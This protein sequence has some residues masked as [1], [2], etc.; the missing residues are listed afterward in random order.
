MDCMTSHGGPGPR[1]RSVLPIALAVVLVAIATAVVVGSSRD[2]V[3]TPSSG[4]PPDPAVITWTSVGLL[5]V[6]QSVIH[7]PARTGAGLA[8]TFTHDLLGAALAAINI[9][10]RLTP[11]AGPAVVEATAHRQCLGDVEALL[12]TIR[13]HTGT[14]VTGVSVPIEYFYTLVD[15]DPRGDVVTVAIAVRTAQSATMGGY[16]GYARTLQWERAGA[17]VG[18]WSVQLPLGPPRLVASVEHYTSLGPIG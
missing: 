16:G 8:T 15:G 4:P 5:P 17:G 14:T 9:S 7:G 10:S 12:A 18:D 6:P 13:G 1:R 2:D 3:S 11:D